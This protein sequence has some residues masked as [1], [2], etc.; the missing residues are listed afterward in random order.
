MR[1]S[2]AKFIEDVRG[3]GFV[4][5]QVRGVKNARAH[6][7]RELRTKKNDYRVVA[8][9]ELGNATVLTKR[10]EVRQLIGNEY[11]GA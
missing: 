8:W 10:G 6:K 5:I 11:K 3:N 7:A 1:T 4:R 9:D 2:I